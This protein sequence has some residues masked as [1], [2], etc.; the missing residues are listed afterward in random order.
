MS[1]RIERQIFRDK[2]T[3]SSRSS[4]RYNLHPSGLA[5]LVDFSYAPIN[6]RAVFTSAA[7]LAAIL[8]A[9]AVPTNVPIS[10]HSRPVK[11][12]SHIMFISGFVCK[13]K[14]SISK[15]SHIAVLVAA[16]TTGGKIK[17][18]C[19]AVFH[20]Y[21]A[22]LKDKDLDFIRQS[23][24]VEYIVENGIMTIKYEKFGSLACDKHIYPE[25]SGKGPAAER[26]DKHARGVGVNVYGI[27]TAT[28]TAHSI[29]GG[30]AHWGATRMTSVTELAINT[31]GTAVGTT[32]GVATS[33]NIIA[34]QA[35]G[36]Y[37]SRVATN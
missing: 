24:D 20:G 21:A 23:K 14:D 29:F 28:Y 11:A 17:H 34:V 6:I 31:A 37:A 33:A 7:A 16:S 3:S 22:S 27:D 36:Q 18:K 13:L 26:L 15:D 10:K 32:S 30:L 1:S 2:S 19:V 35:E 5:N 9:L 25:V 8:P 4:S 12:S